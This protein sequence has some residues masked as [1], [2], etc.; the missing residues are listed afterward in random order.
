MFARWALSKLNAE[1]GR[2]RLFPTLRL[3]N[4]KG[5]CS[6]V[7]LEFPTTELAGAVGPRA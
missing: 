7:V 1:S 2:K 4:L 6:N 3:F 5:L